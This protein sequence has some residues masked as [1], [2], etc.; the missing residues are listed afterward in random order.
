MGLEDYGLV[1]KEK[2]LMFWKDIR[3]KFYLATLVMIVII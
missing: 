2:I 1:N 3:M